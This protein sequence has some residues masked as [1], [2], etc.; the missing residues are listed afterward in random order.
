MKEGKEGR[1]GGREGRERPTRTQ[2]SL[3]VRCGVEK[4]KMVG[5]VWVGQLEVAV[6]MLFYDCL[7][8]IRVFYS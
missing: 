1:E 8:M 2:S 7:S 3:A 4:E 6:L 5:T